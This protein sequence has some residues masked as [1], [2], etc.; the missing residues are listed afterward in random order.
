M[1]TILSIFKYKDLKQKLFY[2]LLMILFYRLGS[3]IP[4]TGMDLS[5]LN[6]MIDSNSL[7]SFIDLFSGGSLSRFS[8]FAL[9][10]LP[11]INASIIIQMMSFVIPELKSIMEEGE[12][13]RKKISQWTRYLAVLFSIVQGLVITIGFKSFI[14]PTVTF[15]FFLVYSLVG[16]VAGA[17]LVMYIGE[18]M[19]E[20]GIGNGASILI[21]VGIISQMPFYIKNTYSLIQSG[22]NPL[23][24]SVVAGV[25]VFIIF[26]IVLIQEA[27]RRIGVQYAKRVVGRK[28][29]GGQSTYIPLRLI[30]GGVLPIIFASAFL[31]F[32]LVISS[33]VPIEMVKTF[34]AKYYTY[35]GIMYN[36]LFCVLIFFFTY[37]YTAISFSPA[38]LSDNIKKYGGFILGVRPGKPTEKYLEAIV[39]KLTFFG[40]FFLSIIALLPI[41]AAASTNVNSFMGLGGTALLII[42][43]VSLD[44]LKQIDSFILQ[45]EYENMV[46]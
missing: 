45:K 31:Q 6:N 9:G 4:I 10:I 26:A 27:Q 11:Y 28:M 5:S 1:V 21:F 36:G 46:K 12:A 44:L 38:E 23:N 14:L 42:V 22:T 8:I 20:N 25:L 15:S 17:C 19:T 18:L 39:T 35:D 29:Y 40:A 43:G 37:F 13:G 24:V 41:I 2:T 30:Q 3:H 32:P 7:I 33:F 34:F 16:L